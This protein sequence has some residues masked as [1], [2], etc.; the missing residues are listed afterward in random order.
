MT[1]K[2]RDKETGKLLISVGDSAFDDKT[3]KGP[4]EP[5][6]N[7][8]VNAEI[9]QHVLSFVFENLGL[10]SHDISHPIVFTE[11]PCVPLESR[12]SR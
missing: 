6:T 9:L 3:S 8:I 12:Q 4:F 10:V 11:A 2:V 7:I 1:S 5:G